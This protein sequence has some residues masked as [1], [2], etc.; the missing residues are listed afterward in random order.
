LLLLGAGLLG[1]AAISWWLNRRNT[2]RVGRVQA[3]FAL[4]DD[5]ASATEAADVTAAANVRIKAMFQ[6][7]RVR[8]WRFVPAFQGL[9]ALPVPGE[10]PE[11]S[12][13]V[14]SNGRRD[15]LSLCY[16][17][18]TPVQVGNSLSSATLRRLRPPG[19]PWR[20]R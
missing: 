14:G 7:P 15:L 16:Q 1:T 12:V 18:R 11:P 20:C 5:I 6:V 17:N 8:I 3:V 9:D 2:A 10:L 13:P 4:A 19:Q